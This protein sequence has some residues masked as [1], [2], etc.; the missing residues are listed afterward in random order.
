LTFHKSQLDR[1]NQRLIIFKLGNVD[2]DG[3][4]V[5]KPRNVVTTG[6]KK[7][8]HTSVYFNK[9]TFTSVGKYSTQAKRIVMN[10][11]NIRVSADYDA[12]I[13]FLLPTDSLQ[14]P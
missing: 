12:D 11:R 9:P 7:G 1:A 14:A 2:D 6:V 4:P 5:I 10:L 13:P 3:K 8:K